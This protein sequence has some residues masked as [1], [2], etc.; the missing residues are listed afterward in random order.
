M[1]KNKR[2]RKKNFIFEGSIQKFEEKIIKYNL[3]KVKFSEY[4]ETLAEIMAYFSFY[5][6]LTQNELKNLTGFSKSTIST[7]LANLVNIGYI[8]R[9]MKPKTHE[10]EYYH[11]SSQNSLDEVLGSLAKEIS[12]FK[13]KIKELDNSANRGK[14]GFKLLLGRLR[15]ALHFFELYEKILDFV[16]DQDAELEINSL[17]EQNQKKTISAE[18]FNKI[19]EIFDSNIKRKEDSIIDFFRHESAYS[20][21]ERY[22]LISYVYFITRKILTQDKLRLLTSLSLGKVSQVVNTLLE[23][24][25]IEKVDKRKYKELIPKKDRRKIFYSMTSIQ[26]S[27]MISGVN[28][29][30]EILKWEDEF[31]AM[32][33]ELES[34]KQELKS[35][36]GYNEVFQTIENYLNLMP[37]YRKACVVFLKL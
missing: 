32:K 2:E 12:F 35:L 8:K 3:E 29:L 16:Q 14:K 27:F 25:C 10:Y 22:T 1:S 7:S 30:R 15:E 9:E 36:N 6:R 4:S 23:K 28:S 34:N 17:L 31:R 21:L 24:Q 33:S 26:N 11:G 37:L 5:G 19:D 18:E 20:I 13:E